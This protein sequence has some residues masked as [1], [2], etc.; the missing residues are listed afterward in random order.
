MT[1]YIGNDRCTRCTR[2]G[3]GASPCPVCGSDREVPPTQLH[4]WVIARIEL[5]RVRATCR[6][7]LIREYGEV[8]SPVLLSYVG[9]Q[10]C[11]PDGTRQLTMWGRV[12]A[13]VPP[14]L[15]KR[16]YGEPYYP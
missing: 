9:K 1:T 8:P 15:P 10:L 16:Q 2:C 7:A 12:I 11:L 6:E 3:G 14:L 5:R 13:T 4:Q